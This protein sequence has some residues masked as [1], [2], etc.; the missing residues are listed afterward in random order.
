[1][2]S[3]TYDDEADR[4]KGNIEDRVRGIKDRDDLYFP[5]ISFL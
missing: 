2:L 3:G 5:Q 1:M 4:W